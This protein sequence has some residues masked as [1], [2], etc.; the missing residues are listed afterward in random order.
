[1]R[2]VCAGL[3]VQAGVLSALHAQGGPPLETDDPG[4][5]GS[6]HLE[7]NVAMEAERERDGTFYDL[8]IVDANLGVGS[9][10]QLKIEVPWRLATAPS[11]P[12]RA[13]LGNV[14]LGV[15]WRF[16]ES[17]GMAIST[18][19][20]AALEGSRGARARGVADPGTAVLLP[21]EVAWD[22]GTVSLGA[23]V[24]YQ[25]VEDDSELVYGLAIAHEARPWLELLGECHGGGDT[26]FTGI[27]L[28][29]GVGLRG[30]IA[31]S[32]SILAA[33]AAGVAG[34]RERRPDRRVYSGVQLRW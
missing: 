5:P 3:I 30:R 25:H 29:C 18:Y 4:T 7:L 20:Q 13:A 28:L 16:A 31:Q 2:W 1:M 11:G 12:T 24:G 22:L 32:V 10:V 6:G 34:S 17:N 9:S 33:L 19:P 23:E 8:P 14:V 27:G 21:L 15:K 26:H